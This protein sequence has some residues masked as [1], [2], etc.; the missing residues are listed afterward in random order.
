[1]Q[2]TVLPA[3]V[4]ISI[5]PGAVA[6]ATKTPAPPSRS[7]FPAAVEMVTVDVVV[8]DR[9]GAPVNDLRR[10]DFML[11]EDGVP[12]AIATFEPID[13]SSALS[14]R[15]SVPARVSSNTDARE[16]AARTFVLVFDGL[17]ISPDY[18]PAARRAIED[19][20]ASGLGADD[21]VTVIGT[22]S[23][24]WLST[25]LADGREQLLAAIRRQQGAATSETDLDYMSDY[26]AMCIDSYHDIGIAMRVVQRWRAAGFLV[27]SGDPDNNPDLKGSSQI[28]MQV[29]SRARLARRVARDRQAATL[30]TLR[31]V[32]RGLASVKGRKAVVL[33]SQGFVFDAD[34]DEYREVKEA[35]RR[36]NVAIY[37]VDV[38]GLSSTAPVSSAEWSAPLARS[39]VSDY[40]AEDSMS[41]DGAQSLAEDSGGFTIRNTNDLAGAL[42]RLVRESGAYYLIGYYPTRTTPD[43]KFRRIAVEVNRKDATVRA[44]RG[45]YAAQA[46]ES[47]HGPEHGPRRP[48]QDAL[49]SPYDVDDVP[50]RLTTYSFG[51]ATPGRLRTSVVADVDVRQ[52]HF[53]REDGRYRDALDTLLVVVNRKTDDV[54]RHD[55]TIDLSL[56]DHA[57][58]RLV[59]AAFPMTREFELP[60][61][62][63]QAKLI[64]RER[65]SGRLGS[66][67]HEFTV[68]SAGQLRLS[69]P[70][71]TDTFEEGT[72]QGRPQLVLRANRRFAPSAFLACHFEVYGA[73]T[74]GPY[75]RPRVLC[76]HKVLRSDGVPVREAPP[77]AIDGSV[78]YLT[79]LLG[80][81]LADFEP[82]D[83][84]LVV[85]V[86]DE[87]SGRTV[88]AV[89]PF[90]VDAADPATSRR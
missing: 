8:A 3:L 27:Q 77:T 47:A 70:I 39:D 19:L 41:S 15:A 35:A 12:Q 26:E 50:L 85:A 33:A 54:Q 74:S 34:I 21:Y 61:G 22:Q 4:A 59:A 83:Y 82:G 63:Y 86:T 68:P 46:A 43:G 37:F 7:T 65:N 78:G 80:F 66:V 11:S 64:V 48:F 55:Q 69:S 25:H 81:P 20:L 75:G 73:E 9:S 51:E 62:N 89:E 23:T 1:M 18:A 16:R 38:R 29:A 57:H 58:A 60:P 44:R 87:V 10:D 5:C 84:R 30:Q 32:V 2:R 42:Q 6:G 52:F 56:S 40:A 72:G 53:Q 31:R 71:L 13:I 14:R 90:A 67:T 17:H 79:R 36:A 49:D 28:E 45:Y 88:E 76:S 24:T